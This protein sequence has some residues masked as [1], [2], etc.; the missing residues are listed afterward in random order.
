MRQEQGYGEVV[1]AFVELEL[2]ALPSEPSGRLARICK[3]G[4]L[5]TRKH[6]HASHA[7]YSVDIEAPDTAE[8]IRVAVSS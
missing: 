1:P 8:M 6:T 2:A 4:P 5:M 7:R 3:G